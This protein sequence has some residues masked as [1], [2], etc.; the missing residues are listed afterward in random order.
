MK[1][2]IK[3]TPSKKYQ[4][5]VNRTGYKADYDENKETEMYLEFY[6][7]TESNYSTKT[8]LREVKLAPKDNENNTFEVNITKA[9]VLE[10]RK[11]RIRYQSKSIT[12]S[13]MQFVKYSSPTTIQPIHFPSNMQVQDI[14][15]GKVLLTWDLAGGGYDPAEDVYIDLRGQGSNTFASSL[16]RTEWELPDKHIG[17]GTINYQ[18]DFFRSPFTWQHEDMRVRFEFVK[19]MNHRKINKVEIK[20]AGGKSFKLSWQTDD[21]YFLDTYNYKIIASQENNGN[22]ISETFPIKEAD[23][24]AKETT[25]T[26]T[27]SEFDYCSTT[28]IYLMQYNDK[29]IEIERKL[30]SDNYVFSS[31]TKT[32]EIEEFTA[33]TGFYSTH[34]KLNW[35]VNSDNQFAKYVIYRKEKTD[36]D[37]D[38]DIYLDEVMHSGGRTNYSFEDDKA[39]PGVY[40][41]YTIVGQMSCGE[42]KMSDLVSMQKTGFILPLGSISGRV[43]FDG[44]QGVQGVTVRANGEGKFRNKV[45]DFSAIAPYSVQNTSIETPYKK[46]M[47]S[48]TNFSIQAWVY[49]R[50]ENEGDWGGDVGNATILS[51][52]DKYGLEVQPTKNLIYFVLLRGDDIK[53]NFP[54]TTVR[55]KFQHIT[56]TYSASAETGTGTATLYIDGKQHGDPITKMGVSTEPFEAMN[57]IHIGKWMTKSSNLNGYM[58]EFRLWNRTLTAEEVADNYDTYLTGRE[59]D[60]VLYYRFDE[61]DNMS[62][63]FDLSGKDGKFN[64]NHG[65]ICGRLKRTGEEKSVPSENQLSIK[66]TT[67]SKGYYYINTIP[68]SNNDYENFYTIVPS[69][70]DH[71]FNPDTRRLNF[72]EK[73][74]DHKNIDFND[75]SKFEVTGRVIYSDNS[76]FPVEGCQFEIDDRLL[77]MANGMPVQSDDEG[78]FTIQVPIG[79]HKV[80]VVKNGH[81]FMNDGLLLDPENQDRYYNENLSE[82]VFVD[83]TRV[84]LV[85]R[86]VGGLQEHNKPLGFAESVNNIGVTTITLK[87]VKSKYTLPTGPTEIEHNQGEWR[88]PGSKENDV[89]KIKYS[90]HEMKITI[91][92]ESGEF[93]A[94]LIPEK[95]EIQP[96]ERTTGNLSDIMPDSYV[97]DL[98]NSPVIQEDMLKTSIRTWTDSVYVNEKGQVPGYQKFEASDTMRYHAEWKHIYQA[99]PSFSVAQVVDGEEVNYFGE[100][101]YDYSLP[102]GG[103]EKIPLVTKGDKVEYLFEHP[104][105]RQGIQYQFALNAF[106]EYTND[107][108]KNNEGGGVY[109]YMVTDGIVSFSNTLTNRDP[110][111]IQLDSLGKGNYIFTCGIPDLVTGMKQFDATIQVGSFSYNWNLEESEIT[112]WLLGD[113]STGTNFLTSG[114]NQIAAILRDPPGTHSYAYI[115]EGTTISSRVTTSLTTGLS[116]NFAMTLNTGPVVK[117][118]VG[119]GAGIITEAETTIE[120]GSGMKTETR[121]SAG[122][123]LMKKTTLTERFETSPSPFHVGHSADVFVGYSTNI[124]YGLTNS[125]TIEE[126][127]VPVESALMTESSGK[128]SIVKTSAMAFGTTFDTRFALAESE[129][130]DGMIPQWEAS[131]ELMLKEPSFTIPEDFDTPI[132]RSVIP[133]NDPN[134]GKLNSD[135]LFGDKATAGYDNPPSYEIIFPEN[136]DIASFTVDSIM[137]MVNQ[138]QGWKETLK[139]N[140]EE[141]VKLAKKGFDGNFTMGASASIAPSISSTV[142]QTITTSFNLM[143]NPSVSGE[144]GAKFSGIGLKMRNTTEIIAESS[145]GTEQ[146]TETVVTT[147]FRLQ[148]DGTNDQI[149]VDY[150]LTESGTYAFR[151]RGG[152]TSCPYEGER[153]THY[154]EP[155][156][157]KLSEATMKVEVPKIDVIGETKALFVPEN[158]EAIFKLSLKNESEAKKNVWYI[159]EVDENSNTEGAIVSMDGGIINNGR[160]LYIHGGEEMIKTLTVK[161][162]SA[163]VYDKIGIILRSD[164]EIF[165]ADTAYVSVEFAPGCSDVQIVSPKSNAIVNTITGDI[166]K[167]TLDKFDRGFPHFGYIR[168]DYRSVSSPT[169]T[170]LMNFYTDN[171]LFGLANGPKTMVTNQEQMIN[172]DWNMKGLSDG[173][174][175]IRASAIC[176]DEEDGVT[177]VLAQ[178]TTDPVTI[179]KDKSRPKSLGSPSPI[180]GILTASDEISITFNEDIQTDELIS[181]NFS[182]TG[183]MNASQIANPSVG[184]NFENAG[185]AFTE[186]PLYVSESFSIETW[187]KRTADTEGTLFA[188]GEGNEYISL[189][190]DINGHVLVTI[191]NETKISS[192][193]LDNRDAWKYIGL[194]YNRTT[195]KLSVYL[196]SSSDT[197]SVLFDA[198]SFSSAPST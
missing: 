67:D 124:L 26:V 158:R 25:V 142:A 157:H 130:V 161:K 118:F 7:L 17:K 175:E 95:Y 135:P 42:N 193:A 169:W 93:M 73:N 134:F 24:N 33:S 112:A 174:Y 44:V 18:F 186:L 63:V 190:F 34:V 77:T 170:N 30:V 138:I 189:G 168:L 53:F 197:Q 9:E 70:G 154:F 22:P 144:T 38:T 69:F 166:L 58:D 117:T 13:T 65:T 187:F 68:Y 32:S 195:R 39:I 111:P 151:T 3:S 196:F 72:K 156:K 1:Y 74:S 23:A 94:W 35:K 107:L 165:N 76:N 105:F 173:G 167:I 98:S 71:K 37:L 2:L 16:K 163:D 89:T 80:R 122:L 45:L 104:V 171:T 133:K 185:M 20:P 99:K 143:I 87:P 27:N 36:S 114:P 85:G 153:L 128:Y 66:A 57:V 48:P 40:Y 64:M 21:G 28:T 147:G 41:T 5:D 97:L 92:P 136:Y 109:R 100:S 110:E 113:K 132:Y 108:N 106:E 160:T 131:L 159:L 15:A 162:G 191:G 55:S 148:E 181:D 52:N 184:L 88:K 31:N 155:G 59:D 145:T 91:S 188:Y 140:E 51:S 101:E 84:K 43:S 152:Q 121:L 102:E 150:G 177:Y 192:Y 47:F 61:L 14:G 29:G 82:I 180:N 182:V 146:T 103:T 11:L 50:A 79:Y 56:V 125:V 60:L 123:D 172:Y 176:L 10:G 90:N 120:V 127:D 49:I 126:A 116:T 198:V 164:C 179:T 137:W 19:N 12:K 4:F 54:Y 6:K 78:E 46:D 75:E 8:K 178:N 119:L 62:E 96:I 115:E 149:T 183:V 139:R 194:S 141:K 129:I 83:E 86:V 81:S